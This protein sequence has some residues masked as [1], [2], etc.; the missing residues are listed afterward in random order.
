MQ[1]HCVNDV[2]SSKFI[3]IQQIYNFNFKYYG[4]N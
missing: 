3:N 1:M 4:N 2:K